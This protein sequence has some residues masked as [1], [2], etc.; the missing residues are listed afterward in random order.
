[1]RKNR[2]RKRE[3]D[4]QT[5][6]TKTMKNLFKVSMAAILALGMW[7]C[8]KEQPVEGGA[9][10]L[11]FTIKQPVAPFVTRA[12]IATTNEWNIA[13]MD[14]YAVEDGTANNVAKLVESTDYTVAQDAATHTFT[15]TMMD[16]WLQNNGGKTMNFYFVGNDKTSNSGGDGHDALA[17]AQDEASFKDALT[18]DQANNAGELTPIAKPNGTANNLLFTTMV[19]VPNITGTV[20]YSGQLKRRVARFDIEVN[21]AFVGDFALTKVKVEKAMANG[22]VFGAGNAT[23]LSSTTAEDYEDITA[24]LGYNAKGNGAA[25]NNVAQAAFYTYPATMGSAADDMK[26]TIYGEL[27]GEAMAFPVT[28]PDNT[29][30]HANFRYTLRINDPASKDGVVMISEDYE[31][32]DIFD[33]EPGVGSN[34][35][36]AAVSVSFQGPYNSFMNNTLA[37]GSAQ[38]TLTI[39]AQSSYGVIVKVT[40]SQPG[41]VNVTKSASFTRAALSAEEDIE[42]TVPAGT[43][44]FVTHID[45]ISTTNPAD[46][47]RFTIARQDPPAPQA[48]YILYMDELSG[49]L[50]AGN[51]DNSKVRADNM[52]FFKFGSVIGF[53]NNPRGTDMTWPTDGSAIMFNPTNLAWN[54]DITDYASLPY[55][56][57]TSN[58]L[59][60]IPG[61][62][63]TDYP[64]NVNVADGYVDVPNVRAGKGDPCMLVGY[65]GAQIQAMTDSELY[66]VLQNAKLRLPTNA[67][68]IAF[69]DASTWVTHGRFTAGTPSI[70]TF[71]PYELPAVGCRN[72]TNI[73]AG[74]VTAVNV[75]GFYWS[76]TPGSVTNVNNE[77]DRAH[78]INF[79]STAIG[80]TNITGYSLGQAIRCVENTSP[81]QI[82]RGSNILYVDGDVL[83][84]GEYD[85]TTVTPENMAFF[86]FGSVIGINKETTGMNNKLGAIRITFDPAS[87]DIQIYDNLPWDKQTQNKYPG[88][89]GYDIDD[90]ANN[91]TVADDDYISPDN[92]IAGKGDPCMLVGHSATALRTM[93]TQD[94]QA[95]LDNA[96]YRLPTMQENQDLWWSES[97]DYLNPA[98]PGF[99][100]VG[101]LGGIYML[102]LAGYFDETG[103]KQTFKGGYW[104][105]TPT[106][107]QWGYNLNF[108]PSSSD[109]ECSLPYSTALAVR[110]VPNV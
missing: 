38:A 97:W 17:V 83:K 21:E 99:A 73:A 29:P 53:D 95:V 14:V 7:S 68:N 4:L 79:T 109:P 62:V 20:K 24:G 72:L 46:N 42:I 110:C 49:T 90:Y 56:A 89:P 107:D 13:A 15:I 82:K 58:A 19:Q 81:Q 51:F 26:I 9:T 69:A 76:S 34:P 88:I 35:L 102:P 37:V 106:D 94:L 31:D 39:T 101:I 18:D 103:A 41:S 80:P 98:H 70:G 84:V 105:S 25:V 52:A 32:G 5:K 100:G 75:N 59:P 36:K 78:R 60:S 28:V 77:H 50:A 87:P 23:A 64:M 61:Y 91:V 54:S 10:A 93:S 11:Q 92:L 48:P 1:M 47:E 40:E 66:R 22:L 16:A 30:I 3:T 27:N 6:K 108:D 12:D 71:G 55:K 43:T 63:S 86:K 65:T 45:I 85:G 44:N 8:M 57:A 67:E 104:S 2:T 96:Q 74:E 33:A